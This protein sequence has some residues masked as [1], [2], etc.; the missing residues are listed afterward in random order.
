[1]TRV[2]DVDG[3]ERSLAWLAQQY[4]GCH[5]EY[6]A[7]KINLA[8]FA[9]YFALVAIYVTEG[10]AV[11]KV[12]IRGETGEKLRHPACLSWPSL[13]APDPGLA[14]LSGSGAPVLWTRRGVAQFTETS[15]GVTGFGLGPSFGPLYQAWVISPSAPSDCLVGAGMKGGTD[16]RGPLFGVFQLT[17]TAG[18][19][20]PS[21][22][23]TDLDYARQVALALAGQMELSPQQVAERAL[24]IA[25]LLTG[26][27]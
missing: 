3:T 24:A 14:D 16:H 10:P 15:T 18:A 2:F 20:E 17:P 13:A 21:P 22:A 26:Q 23:T 4:D 7:G 1:M 11:C 25:G 6:A 27:G 8:G 5:P 19:G 9:R 12:E